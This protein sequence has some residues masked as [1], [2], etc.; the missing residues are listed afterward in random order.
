MRS[1]FRELVK[2]LM[3]GKLTGSCYE[4][5][6]LDLAHRLE[7]CTG[8]KQY[9]YLPKSVKA[10]VD[11]IVDDVSVNADIREL[12]DIWYK[13]KCSVFATY[14]DQPPEKLP[15]SEEKTFK[16]IRNALVY[17]AVRLGKELRYKQE[18]S[19]Q[20]V[21]RAAL[22]FAR[23]VARVFYDN[24]KQYD[25]DDDDIDRKLKREIAAVKN[26]QNIVM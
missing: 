6:L 14:T 21:T 22:R 13:A 23:S 16:A 8:K 7:R 2:D 15:M 4:D 5:N 11:E 24:Y 10:L 25:P 20:A 9:G 1:R 18:N 19:K 3:D 26:G 12:Y 17:E